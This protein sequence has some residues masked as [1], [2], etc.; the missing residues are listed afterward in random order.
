MNSW[1]VRVIIQRMYSLVGR[2]SRGDFAL[3]GVLHTTTR[4]V[5]GEAQRRFV[6]WTAGSLQLD[7][8]E[9]QNDETS[10]VFDLEGALGHLYNAELS[11]GGR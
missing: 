11:V 3:D 7:S 8:S 9:D 2:E 4:L 5:D 1:Q 10:I 6:K